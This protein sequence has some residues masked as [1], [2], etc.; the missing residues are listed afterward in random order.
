MPSKRIIESWL[1]SITPYPFS[2][3]EL[4]DR[5]MMLGLEVE[6]FEN[7]FALLEGFVVGEVLTKEK[8]PNA[9][10][11]S[12]CTVSTGAEQHTVVCGAPNVAAGQKIAFAPVGTRIPK[13][14]FTIEQRKIRGVE[15]QGM[16]C[17]ESELGLGDSHEGI[18]VLPPDATAGT[19][20]GSV[21]G[22]VVYDIEITANRGDW[23]SH[24]GVA[25]EVAAITGNGIF[26][27]A[28]DF[29]EAQEKTSDAVAITIED[30]SL[31]PRYVAR[32]VRGVTIGPSPAWLQDVLRKAGLRPRNNVVDIAAYVMLEC[33]HP[34]HAFDYDLLA[35]KQIVVKS[36]RGGEKFTTLDGVERELPAGALLICDAEKPV[37]I[38]GVMGG[39]NS[40]IGDATANVLIESAYFNPSSIRR[41]AKALG[42]TTDA[43]YRFERGADIGNTIYAIN[44]AV[45]MIAELAG[46]E[47]LHGALDL[48]PNV[49]PELA[50]EL[51]FERTAAMLGIPID[52]DTQIDL[53]KRLGFGV[54]RVDDDRAMVVVP[55]FRSDIFAEIDLIEEIAR[56]NGYDAIPADSRANVAFDLHA[57]PLL[58][59]IEQTRAFFVD[60]G[61]AETVSLHMTDPETAER[62]G[63]PVALRNALG[64]DYSVL[65]TSLSPSMAKIAV[66]NQRHG[67]PDLRL[68]EIGKAFRASRPDRGIIPGIVEM[69]ELAVLIAGAAEPAA[70]DIPARPSDIHEL[71]GLFDRYFSRI[72]ARDVAYRLVEEAQWGIAPPALAVTIGGEEIARIGQ[73]DEWLAER[74]EIEG[75]PVLAL[76][77]LE[78][79]VPRLAG[80]PQ[81]RQPSKFPVVQRDLSLLV[82]AATPNDALETTIRS[83]GGQLLSDVRLFDLYKGKGIDP[84]KKSL[85][86]ALYFTSYERTLDDATIEKQIETIVRRLE[87]EHRA[88]L[89]AGEQG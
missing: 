37:A 71:R 44:R 24:L 5:L 61:F 86:Y 2:P 68:F 74:Y 30:A 53:L 88:Q 80:Q 64:R 14:E 85:A 77:D 29:L 25:R 69:Q 17:S 72:G 51:R 39:E 46:G 36:S 60:N 78:R 38:A 22:D 76:L 58:K 75:K 7:R 12:V 79:L 23:L 27:P 31:C 35:G 57:D 65:R 66:L 34:L 48:Y 82:D 70:W 19:P 67:R 20:L 6:S 73:L 1:K 21:L 41:T 45:S 18:M 50:I 11:L 26:L 81:F 43:S 47:V 9:D 83:A 59:L 62:F 13:G 87:S 15:S 54:D 42:L 63:K 55:S 56:L 49:R 84:G 32:V 3:E 8:H 28:T 52:A 33:G 89:R 40:E 4:S 10:K 16:I